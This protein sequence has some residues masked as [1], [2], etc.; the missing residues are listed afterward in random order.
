MVC[1]RVNYVGIIVPDYL[2]INLFKSLYITEKKFPFKK[3]F[4]LFRKRQS[5]F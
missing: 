1:E 2:Q 5:R 3:Y 4:I